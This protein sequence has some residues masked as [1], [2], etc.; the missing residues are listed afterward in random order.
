MI[1][2][3]GCGAGEFFLGCGYGAIMIIVLDLVFVFFCT[4]I[5]IYWVYLFFF[6]I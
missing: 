2:K 3:S 4:L 1:F 5:L 6:I